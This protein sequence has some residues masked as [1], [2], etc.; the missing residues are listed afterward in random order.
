EIPAS[1]GG[2]TRFQMRVG[3]RD[4][5][6]IDFVWV[7]DHDVTA[8]RFPGDAVVVERLEWGN[9][10]GRPVELTDG[11]TVLASGVDAVW[12]ALP[13]LLARK[14]DERRA[15]RRLEKG[16]IGDV[17]HEIEKLRLAERRLDLAAPPAT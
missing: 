3:N 1:A 11:A 14:A 10:Y 5:T 7:D 17:N 12:T 16:A 9:F 15:I 2:G 6:D 8:R 13:A 4:L